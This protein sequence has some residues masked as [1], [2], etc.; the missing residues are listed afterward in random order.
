VTLSRGEIIGCY[1]IATLHNGDRQAEWMSKD[2][3]EQIRER[4]E[5][6]KAFKA[7][8]V[9]SCTWVTDESEMWRKTVIRR[10]YKYLPRTEQMR[11]I[12]EAIALQNGDFV[13]SDEQKDYI[14]HLMDVLQYENQQKKF[15]RIDMLTMS[16]EDAGAQIE[17][18]KGLAEQ[19]ELESTPNHSQKQ[20]SEMVKNSVAKENS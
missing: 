7:G 3:I 11:A 19:Y 2:E 12:D 4:S 13:I 9:K 16:S 8:K 17:K 10:I 6:Y 15:L 14:E 18:M 1:A 20:I 5:T